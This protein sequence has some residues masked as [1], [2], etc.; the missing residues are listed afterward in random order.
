M[1]RGSSPSKVQSRASGRHHRPIRLIRRKARGQRGTRSKDKAVTRTRN[2]DRAGHKRGGRPGE[3]SARQPSISPAGRCAPFALAF[4]SNWDAPGHPGC[5]GAIDTGGVDADVQPAPSGH[6]T[7]VRQVGEARW[8]WAHCPG[9]PWRACHFL[10]R[11]VARTRLL[12]DRPPIKVLRRVA[13]PQAR[14][15]RGSPPGAPESPVR[16]RRRYC[17]RTVRAAAGYL[18]PPAPANKGRTGS[19]T[20]AS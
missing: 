7:T 17:A 9:C 16:L 15:W 11:S 10:L 5:V 13:H 4:A 19:T 1:I 8:A 18:R 2:E 3:G 20:G 14:R 6:A 12:A